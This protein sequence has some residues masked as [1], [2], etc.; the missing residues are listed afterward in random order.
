MRKNLL[1]LILG[2]VLLISFTALLVAADVKLPKPPAQTEGRDYRTI[3]TDELMKDRDVIVKWTQLPDL[4]PTGM[5]VSDFNNPP[6]GPYL[7]ADDFLCTTTGPITDIAIWGSWWMDYLPGGNPANVTFI[8]SIHADIPASEN[9]HGYYSMP[10][11]TLWLDTLPFTVSLFQDGLMEG[12]FEPPSDYEPIGDH[13]CWMYVFHLTDP[14]IQQ[15]TPENPIIYWLDLQATPMDPMAYFGWKTSIYHWNDDAAWTMSVEPTPIGQIW[16]ELRYP[17]GHM[18]AGTSIDLA[19]EIWGEEMQQTG[20]CCFPNGSCSDLTQTDCNIASGTWAGVGTMCLGDNNG[21]LIDDA[22]EGMYPMGACCFADQTC[23]VTYQ[24]PCEA[25]AGAQYKGDGTDCT[26]GNLNGIADICEIQLPIGACCLADGSCAMMTQVAC[27]ALVGAWY[28]GDNIQCQGDL[29][30]NGTDDLCETD[31]TMKWEQLPDLY[32]TGM[33]VSDFY[34]PQF[35]PYLLA[36]DFLCTRTGPINRIEIWGSWY[37]DQIPTAETVGFVLSFHSDI[38]ASQNPYGQYSMPGELLWLDTLYVYDQILYANNLQEGWFEPPSDYDPLGD[39]QCWMYRFRNF[40]QPFIQTG[41]PEQPVIYWLDVQVLLPMGETAFFGWKT[42]QFHWNDDAAWIQAV[43]PL[44]AGAQ[45]FELRYPEMHPLHP[46]SIDLAFRLYGEE[47]AQTGACCFPDGSCQDLTLNDCNSAAGIWGGIGSFCMGDG[48][49]N[50]INDAC[51]GMYPM[52]ACCF[53]DLSCIVTY[54]PACEVVAG[55]QYMG[56]GTDCTDGD[57]SGFADICETVTG[58]CCFS[59]GSCAIMTQANCLMSFGTYKGDGT[60]C[61][62]DY[63]S[64]GIDDICETWIPGDPYKMHFPQ[65][66]NEAGWDV[67]ATQPLVLADDFMCSETG[68]IKDIHFWGSWMHGIEG[69]IMAFVLSLHADI[70]ANPPQIPYSRPG[71]TLWEAY[72][73]RFAAT[74]I[75]PPTPEGWFDPS[76]MLVLP[77]DHFAY[78]QYDIILDPSQWFH[79]EAGT[80]YWLNISAIVA[81]PTLTQWGWKSSINHWNDDAVWAYWGDLNWID[82]WEPPFLEQSLDLAFVITGEGHEVSDTCSYYKLPYP[83]YAPNGMPDFDQKQDNWTGATGAWSYCGPVALADCFW[84]FDSKFEPNPQDP[85]PFYPDPLSPGLNDGYPLVQS[86]DPTGLWDDHDINNVLP[87]VDSLALYSNCNN[88]TTGTFIIDLI[89]GATNWLNSRGLGGSYSVSPVQIPPFELIRDQ[90]LISQDVIL[91]LGFYELTPMGDCNRLGGHYVTAAGACEDQWQIC[92]SDPWYDKNEGEPP[93]GSAHGPGVH[94]DAYFVSGPHGTRHHDAYDVF[95]NIPPVCF[96]MGGPPPVIGLSDYPDNYADIMNF[97]MLNQTIP[98][99]DPIPYSGGEIFTL[100]D[101]AVIICPIPD[102]DVNPQGLNYNRRIETD[103]TYTDQFTVCNI[104]GAALTVSGI[105]CDLAWV[106]FPDFTPPLVLNPTECANIDIR[107]NDT[108]LPSGIYSGT[109][110]VSSD[111]PDE[112]VVDLPLIQ[113]TVTEEPSNFDYLPGD[114]NMAGGA[115]PPAALSGDVT[116]LVNYF[117]G[118]LSSVPCLMHNP[119]AVIAPPYFFASADANGDCQLISSDVTKL[120][121]YF[122]GLT[123]LVTCPDYPPNYPPIP[124]SPPTGWPNCATPPP[125]LKTV[126]PTEPGK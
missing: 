36:D 34:H 83:D 27:Q 94:N 122:R 7:L 71:P 20:A 125:L 110:H 92:I 40:E 39:T 55:G 95:L 1:V 121:N 59:D 79:Q 28:V 54:Q 111:D 91:L 107:I 65:L 87:F 49:G 12:W 41:T 70:P 85:R 32:T 24:I 43:E 16:N 69:E 102:I 18:W 25:T 99:Y 115:W 19:F 101:F 120:V 17:P 29:N 124:G 13:V 96:P 42:S 46:Q 84:W 74:P 9:P 67:N 61:F 103:T 44:P 10:G 76:Q 86:Y 88:M 5:D 64:N 15:G 105:T 82:L 6:Y 4:N 58:A 53:A 57:G 3:T 30:A 47:M 90:V 21:N 75:D 37:R 11:A 2:Y 98:P 93:A 89:N 77:N 100:V 48:N 33:D 45:W 108:G 118:L 66:P 78:F 73:T 116:Y 31:P 126:I 63:N 50:Y 72:I 60:V 8:L 22:C 117:R 81:G 35:P 80:I 38:P 123:T 14:F 56:D 97:I 114:V 52:G 26:D 104:G 119:G 106:T 62:G 51:E 23:I 112:P 113:V 109:C 68:W